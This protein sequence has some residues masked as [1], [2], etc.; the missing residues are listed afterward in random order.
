MGSWVLRLGQTYAEVQD[1][2]CSHMK[3]FHL[4]Y[5]YVLSHRQL[6]SGFFL[7]LSFGFGH[8]KFV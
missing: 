8:L 5:R 4:K 6:L 7:D 2:S 3:K 1:Q